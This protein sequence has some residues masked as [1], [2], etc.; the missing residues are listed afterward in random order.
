[1]GPL[2]I[3]LKMIEFLLEVSFSTTE[4]TLTRKT[5]ENSFFSTFALIPLSAVRLTSFMRV[6]G[7]P[8]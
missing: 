4:S 5:L 1:M 6:M 2:L 8:R 7:S 3:F